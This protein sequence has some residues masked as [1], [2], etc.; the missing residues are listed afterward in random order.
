MPAIVI[1]VHRRGSGPSEWL[2][3]HTAAGWS[4]GGNVE[5]M[6][7][8]EV[9]GRLEMSLP[10]GL[11]CTIEPPA[12]PPPLAG[13]PP[14][15]HPAVTAAA[16]HQEGIARQRAAAD[17]PECVYIVF[18]ETN[19]GTGEDSDGYVES[20]WA[21]EAAAD[22]ERLRL[23]RA[24]RDAGAAIW[25]DPDD[26]D[27]ADQAGD[28]QWEHDW[29]V[30]A[31]VVSRAG[32]CPGCGASAAACRDYRAQGRTACCPDCHHVTDEPSAAPGVTSKPGEA[33]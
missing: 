21:T 33:V 22:R 29:R 1:A 15:P 9:D 30:E 4:F 7:V 6:T 25:F 2:T 12:P 5:M 28:A 8:R 13:V 16:L 10:A 3:F 14:T 31:H 18:H 20:V 27:G 26:P 19:T 23:I 11:H 17:A 24:A 32:D